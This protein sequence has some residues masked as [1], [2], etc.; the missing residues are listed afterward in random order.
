M[1]Q[2][3]ATFQPSG[4]R[5]VYNART[6]T[7]PA[8]AAPG[9]LYYVTVYDPGQTGDTGTGT[10]LTAYCTNTA[11]AAH[12]GEPGYIYMGSIVALPAG[13]GTQGGGGGTNGTGLIS[14]NISAQCNSST[15]AFTISAAT[16]KVVWLVWNGQVRYDFTQTGATINTLWTPDTGDGLYAVYTL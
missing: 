3:T 2:V 12:V 14:E 9:L 6:F 7:I 8:P 16:G 4:L 15:T 11:A 5:T 10:T 1:V 13:G